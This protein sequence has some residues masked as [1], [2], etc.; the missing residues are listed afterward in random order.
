MC[1]SF[2]DWDYI[3]IQGLSKQKPEP[4]F[5]LNYKGV[6]LYKLKTQFPFYGLNIREWKLLVFNNGPSGINHILDLFRSESLGVSS[7]V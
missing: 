3:L 4:D 2:E 7:Q 5:L 6:K 1:S